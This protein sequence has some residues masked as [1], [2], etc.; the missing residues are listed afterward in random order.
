MKKVLLI[1]LFF[2]L[3]V[4]A[5]MAYETIIIDFPDGERW[6]KAYYKK[7][8]NEAI[9][10]YTPY[11][12]TSNDWVRSIVI[13]SYN[14]SGYPVRSFSSG[15]LQKLRKANPTAPYKTLRFGTNDA[16]FTRCTDDYKNVKG[17]CEFYR[18]T[19]AHDNIITVHYMN[20]N[21]ENF[22]NNYTI[23]LE[24]IRN[25]RFLNTYYRNDRTLNKSE[26]FEL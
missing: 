15:S 19:K 14:N 2:L 26:Y 21:K 3:S 22:K 20:K 7:V 5:V 11:G 1:S 12:E 4:A 16:I 25:T 6:D 23:W 9:L 18:V 10:Q 8:G 13:H 24:I 17:Q